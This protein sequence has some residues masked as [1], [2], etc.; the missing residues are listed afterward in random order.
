[1][2]KELKIANKIIKY[3]LT[4]KRVKNINVR[5]KPD[6]MVYVSA[7][8]TVPLSTIEGFLL[9]KADV[10]LRALEKYS[11]VEPHKD[12][13]YLL[14]KEVP[15]IRK[16][17]ETGKQGV[18]FDGNRVLLSLNDISNDEIVKA[19]LRQFIDYISNDVLKSF[20]DKGYERCKRLTRSKPILKTGFRKTVWGTCHVNKNQIVLNK[21]LVMLPGECI[22]AV[23][24]HEFCHFVSRYHDKKFYA[25]LAGF[26]PDLKIR[27]Q[28]LKEYEKKIRK[29]IN[30]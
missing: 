26:I 13:I 2:I 27:D 19:L 7:S 24:I 12:V 16:Q 22:E 10:I 21:K 20:F 6:G 5:I 14:G 28:I 18:Q 17:L 15:V 29:G 30:F 25:T 3:E 8:K 23:V 4:R 11:S 1:M 9:E